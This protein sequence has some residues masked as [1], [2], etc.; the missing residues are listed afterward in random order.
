M[1]WKLKKKKM[2]RPFGGRN[3]LEIVNQK[4]IVLEFKKIVY[5]ILKEEKFANSKMSI[6]KRSEN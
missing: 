1:C 4:K 2:M 5:K 6:K 3:W